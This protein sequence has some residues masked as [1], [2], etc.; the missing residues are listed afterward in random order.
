MA[1]NMMIWII[2]DTA[3]KTPLNRNR[4]SRWKKSF[5]SNTIVHGARIAVFTDWKDD[6][7]KHFGFL[8]EFLVWLPTSST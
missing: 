2:R 1:L 6:M 4:A 3:L 5:K 8:A 7:K